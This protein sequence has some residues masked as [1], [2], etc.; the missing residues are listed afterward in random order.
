MSKFPKFAGIELAKILVKKF[1]FQITYQTGSHAVLCKFV[2]D[3]KIVSCALAQ[4]TRRDNFW[5][6]GTGKN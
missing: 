3:E 6:F 1:G 4:G 2:N 5:D